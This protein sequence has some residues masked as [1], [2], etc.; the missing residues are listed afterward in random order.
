[1]LGFSIAIVPLM[2]ITKRLGRIAGGIL[3]SAYV[4][5]VVLLFV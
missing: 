3:I 5:Y 2:L 1:M 4:V